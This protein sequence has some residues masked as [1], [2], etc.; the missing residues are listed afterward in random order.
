MVAIIPGNL[1]PNFQS[2]H[3]IHQDKSGIRNPQGGNHFT[4]EVIVSGGVEEINLGVFVF[5]RNDGCVNGNSPT[6]FLFVIIRKRGSIFDFPKAGCSPRS[7]QESF[8]QHGLA[9]AS[10]GNHGNIADGFS[11]ILFHACPFQYISLCSTPYFKGC[12]L[13]CQKN[14]DLP[15]KPFHYNRVWWFCGNPLLMILIFSDIPTGD[16]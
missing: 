9:S 4:N 14:D 6:D 15:I 12:I 13:T 2:C 7:M 16:D 3:R 8:R 1:G 11:C 5:N 10:V